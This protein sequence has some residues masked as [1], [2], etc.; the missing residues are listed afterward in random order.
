MKRRL[1]A[2]AAVAVTLPALT[3]LPTVVRSEEVCPDSLSPRQCR[4]AE[5]AALEVQVSQAFSGATA[6]LDKMTRSRLQDDH[7]AFLTVR[8]GKEAGVAFDVGAQ[9]ALRRDFLNAVV[10][11]KDKWVGHWANA[12]GTVEVAAKAAGTYNVRV[13]VAELSV[14]TWFCEFDDA[15]MPAGPLIIVGAKSAALAHGGPNEGWTLA[16]RRSGD[17]LLVDALPP[18]GKGGRAPFCQGG[19]DVAGAFFAQ[20]APSV[21]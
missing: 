9:M 14:G 15:A 10:K 12:T 17:A 1:Y 13:S 6:R 16:L 20:A 7:A 11:P 18:H 19:G 8:R 4:A 2:F 5:L 3:S 21:K